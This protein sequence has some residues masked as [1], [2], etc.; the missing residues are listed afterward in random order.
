MRRRVLVAPLGLRCGLTSWMNQPVRIGRYLLASNETTKRRTKQ[1]KYDEMSALE[2][3]VRPSC[4]IRASVWAYIL[5]K[6]ACLNWAVPSGIKWNKK[7]KAKQTRCDTW[8]RL[9]RR[10]VLVAPWGLRCRLTL[11]FKT[12]WNLWMTRVQK[13]LLSKPFDY[14]KL[15]VFKPTFPYIWNFVYPTPQN[16]KLPKR[17]PNHSF[18][19]WFGKASKPRDFNFFGTS[20]WME[21]QSAFKLTFSNL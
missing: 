1:T 13:M 15:N 19:Q 4:A 9:M 14:V 6:S 3:A 10:R 7:Q 11:D 5:D 2:A 16:A 20:G 17:P 12:F 21:S 18:L 8:L